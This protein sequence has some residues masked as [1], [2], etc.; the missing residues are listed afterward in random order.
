VT[1]PDPARAARLTAI[2][3]LERFAEQLRCRYGDE[4]YCPNCDN[5]MPTASECL[6]AAQPLL[7]HVETLTQQVAQLSAV[8][9]ALKREHDT[10]CDERDAAR[11][12]NARLK[13]ALIGS[14]IDRGKAEQ[15]NARLTAE[16][17]QLRR[18]YLE[19]RTGMC[20]AEQQRDT[21]HAALRTFG[22]HEESC[23][24]GQAGHPCTCGLDAALAASAPQKE[25]Q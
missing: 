5:S 19:A 17:A 10:R 25:E 20:Q 4:H 24:V 21:V 2:A 13:D 7:A 15:E 9:E 22:T 23:I 3:E 14:A 12:E 11:Q 1:P 6:A 16:N 18:A 8:K